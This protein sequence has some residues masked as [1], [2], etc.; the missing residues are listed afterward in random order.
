M[1]M[2][3]SIVEMA[4]FRSHKRVV[5][6]RQSPDPDAVNDWAQRPHQNAAMGSLLGALIGD[7]IGSLLEFIHRAPSA[8][9]VE[10]ALAMPGGGFWDVASG[11]VTD[12]GELTVALARALAGQSVFPA[13]AVARQYV[14]WFNSVPFDIGMTTHTALADLTVGQTDVLSNMLA[15]AS[16]N[17]ADSKANGSLMRQ[18]A[19]GIWST[20]ISV[21]EAMNAARSDTRMTH[22]NLACQWAGVAYVVAIRH[23]VL[24]PGQNVAAYAAACD[25]VL[26]TPDAAAAQ[27]RSWLHDARD[28][29]LPA[30]LPHAGYVAIAFTHA[31]H[32]LYN[33]TSYVEA[34]R[35]TLAGGG[36]TDTNACIVGGLV[37]AM[38]GVAGIPLSMVRALL[39][40]DVS[41]GRPR[42][43]WLQARDALALADALLSD[44]MQA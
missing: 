26:D 44:L 35:A 37:G 28:G 22:P 32:H 41:E 34:L 38:H 8:Q 21:A 25:A 6:D 10:G 7:S 2:T 36:D 27:V 33:G 13:Q 16:Q 40:C 24:H 15:N 3:K 43:K 42:P 30:F 14:R 39:N 19:L 31:F 18:S 4:S 11:Q 17:C 29:K 12:D 1:T 9:D 23:L 5:L 20:R